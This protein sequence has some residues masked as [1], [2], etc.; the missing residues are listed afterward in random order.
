MAEVGLSLLCRIGRQRDTHWT[1]AASTTVA[2]AVTLRL[3]VM[4]ALQIRRM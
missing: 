1:L 4:I 2:T 3:R